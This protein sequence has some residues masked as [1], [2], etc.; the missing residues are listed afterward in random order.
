[1]KA[2]RIVDLTLALAPVALAL[3][4]AA[5]GAARRVDPHDRTGAQSEAQQIAE[6]IRARVEQ[7]R[8]ERSD[9]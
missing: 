4:N 7:R 6:R 5:S 3:L 2:D 8:Q 1:M 9:G